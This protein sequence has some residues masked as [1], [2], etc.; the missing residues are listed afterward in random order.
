MEFIFYLD[1]ISKDILN[2][3]I[4]AR[5]L[6]RENIELCRNPMI[7]GSTSYPPDKFIICTENIKR[8]MIDPRKEISRVVAHEAVHV[9]QRCKNNTLI[10]NYNMLK[11]DHTKQS[12]LRASLAA[13]INM[14]NNRDREYEAY[15]L[16]DKPEE[17]LF[18]LK[19]YCLR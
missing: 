12:N 15:F 13:T 6:V 5:Y 18:Y 7:N 11:L 19:K 10:S 14:N 1:S 17:V 16:E 9:A 2:A 8:R 4:R 3:V